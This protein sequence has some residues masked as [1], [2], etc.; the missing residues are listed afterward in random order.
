MSM[1]N[2]VVG[3][4]PFAKL[5][6]VM[7][8]VGLDEYPLGR[9]RDAYLK[10]YD[11]ELRVLVFTRNGGGNREDYQEVFEALKKHPNYIR[12]YDD[13][14]DTT[15]ATIEF[16]VPEQ[17][18]EQFEEM[19]E[20][21]PEERGMVFFRRVVENLGNPEAKDDVYVKRCMEFGKKIFD[22]LEKKMAGGESGIIE[23]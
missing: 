17:F 22:V 7:M 15:Y 19:Y 20:V 21:A 1:Y 13:N 8:G 16:S 12:D 6:I 14:F 4:H 18:K 11:D 9:V 10:K 3:V 23:V 2:Q 5:I